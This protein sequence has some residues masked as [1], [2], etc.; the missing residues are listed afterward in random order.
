MF[1]GIYLTIFRYLNVP[2]NK[3]FQKVFLKKTSGEG[4]RKKIGPPDEI[5]Q[6]GLNIFR[7]EK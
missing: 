2:Q 3:A 6:E 4:F 1:V 5:R 7:M